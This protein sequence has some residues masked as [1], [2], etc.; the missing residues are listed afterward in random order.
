MRNIAGLHDVHTTWRRVCS[1]SPFPSDRAIARDGYQPELTNQDVLF[2]TTADVRGLRV[3]LRERRIVHDLY[4]RVW[5]VT[6]RFQVDRRLLGYRI[7]VGDAATAARIARL[8]G[9]RQGPSIA[10]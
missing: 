1:K 2:G 6:H 3:Y 9:G 5:L 7:T 4:Q 8:W 10:H